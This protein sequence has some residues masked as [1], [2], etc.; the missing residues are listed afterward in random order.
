MNRAKLLIEN[1][2]VYGFGGMIAKLVPFLMLPIVTRLMP[3]T[4]YFGISDLAN[5]LTQFAQSVAV[6]GM[7]DA[8]FRLFFERK[9]DE[10]YRRRVCTT[11]LYFVTGCSFAVAVCMLLLSPLFR[12]ISICVIN[13]SVCRLDVCRGEWVYRAGAHEN[14]K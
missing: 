4:S 8:M 12:R 2:I 14:A 6:M 3:G 9:E 5:S 7:Y 1:V 10:D 13:R 11:A